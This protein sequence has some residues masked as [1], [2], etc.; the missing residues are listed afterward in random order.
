MVIVLSIFLV[1]FAIFVSVLLLNLQ[2]GRWA[3]E[4]CHSVITIRDVIYMKI[5]CY[6]AI[7]DSI[8]TNLS[9]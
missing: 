7:Y 2:C 8:M 5:Q 4:R 6:C 9:V 3:W 1:Y